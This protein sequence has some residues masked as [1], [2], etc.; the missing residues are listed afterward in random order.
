M[1]HFKALFEGQVDHHA[2]NPEHA[3]D[4]TNANVLLILLQS[5]LPIRIHAMQEQLFQSEEA[6]V[7]LGIEPQ[8]TLVF[9]FYMRLLGIRF[10]LFSRGQFLVEALEAG[11]HY[12]DGGL[13]YH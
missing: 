10:R 13:V 2:G 8:L 1:S 9:L 7:L 3:C 6:L 4:P 12:I 11:N 5:L